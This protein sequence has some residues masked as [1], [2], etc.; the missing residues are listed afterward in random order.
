MT[1]THYPPALAVLAQGRDFL[2]TAEFARLIN[3]SGQTIRKN[4]CLTGTA[5]GVRP[6]RVGGRLMWPVSEVA[7]LMQRKG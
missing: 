1:P 3:R 4:L 6:H 5:Y 2:D 7:Q